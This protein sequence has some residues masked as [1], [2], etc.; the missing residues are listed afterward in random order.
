MRPNE[1]SRCC[2]PAIGVILF[3]AAAVGVWAAEDPGA[4]ALQQNQLLRQQQQD[5]LQL[6]MQQYHGTALNPQPDARARQAIQQLE[7]DQALRQQQLQLQQRRELQT[8][9]AVPTEDEG[10]R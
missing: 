8:R 4:G 7:L 2:R 5:Q 1:S 6:R 9:P 3:W 10:V